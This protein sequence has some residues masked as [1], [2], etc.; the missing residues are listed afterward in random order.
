M[1]LTD[2]DFSAATIARGDADNE[3][4]FELMGVTA[5]ITNDWEFSAFDMDKTGSGHI[6]V[7]QTS[8]KVSVGIGEDEK[9]EFTVNLDNASIWIGSLDIHVDGADGTIM[10]WLISELE[11]LLIDTIESYFQV[12]VCILFNGI[13]N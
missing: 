8:V 1:T 11:P 2:I 5:L 12:V 4:V 10:N 13:P 6:M 3:V 9:G 7:N